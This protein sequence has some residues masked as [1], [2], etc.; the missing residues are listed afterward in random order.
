MEV[1]GAPVLGR[2]ELCGSDAFSHGDGKLVVG[3]R[4]GGIRKLP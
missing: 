3:E 1:V 2:G 4:C